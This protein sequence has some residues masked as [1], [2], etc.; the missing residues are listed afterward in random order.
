MALGTGV[1]SPMSRHPLVYALSIR[2]FMGLP[3]PKKMAGSVSAIR[4]RQY[5]S[6][7]QSEYEA[8]AI[9]NM[10]ISFECIDNPVLSPASSGSWKK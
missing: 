3:C 1:R 2:A 10:A 8:S 9:S 7:R 4:E 5:L 6:R